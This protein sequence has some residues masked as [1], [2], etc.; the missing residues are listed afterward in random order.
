MAGGGHICK[1]AANAWLGWQAQCRRFR[2][3][4]CCP[5]LQQFLRCSHAE[6]L[7]RCGKGLL[8]T[9]PFQRRSALVPCRHLRQRK[10]FVQQVAL[11]CV[12]TTS[13]GSC[14]GISVPHATHLVTKSAHYQGCSS[15]TC[16][17]HCRTIKV[18]AKESGLCW[19]NNVS[20]K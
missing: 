3:F 11:D 12:R 5:W 17:P 7:L 8:L 14:I 19:K 4:L 1:V 2:L 15:R 16:S 13:L 9:L 18:P 10:S 6:F 20:S